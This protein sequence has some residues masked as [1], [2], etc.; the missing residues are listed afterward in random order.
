MWR[1]FPRNKP[2]N[3]G[4]SFHNLQESFIQ[5][6]CFIPLQEIDSQHMNE[7]LPS[8]INSHQHFPTLPFR[9]CIAQRLDLN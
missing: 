5:E 6:F 4:L 3:N 8:S 9:Q 1:V 7:L 2:L